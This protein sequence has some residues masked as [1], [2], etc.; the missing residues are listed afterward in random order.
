MSLRDDRASSAPHTEQE[1][2]AVTVGE[3]A[4][5]TSRIVLQ[6]YDPEWPKRF[7]AE[8]ERLRGVLGDR[9]LLIEHVGSTSVPGLIAKPIIDMLLAV[10]DSSDEGAYLSVMESAGYV[11][12]IREPDW[13][14][15]RVFKGP[16]AN[17]NMHVF[18]EGCSEIDR[19]LAFRD[20]LRRDEADRELYARRKRALAEKD[21][22]YV[23]NYADAKSEMIEEILARASR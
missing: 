16:G 15:H 4:P 18:S 11:L 2:R 17:I 22:K 7:A 20:R 21:W 13:Y 6:S 1:I 23:Q 12:R 3:L 10:A 14:E 19:M 8:A 5:L 9:A